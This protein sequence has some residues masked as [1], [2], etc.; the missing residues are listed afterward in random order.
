MTWSSLWIKRTDALTRF[1]LS[2]DA[3]GTDLPWILYID[4]PQPD[5]LLIGRVR[6]RLN[7]LTNANLRYTFGQ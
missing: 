5:D 2:G 3:R 7:Q 6:K 4:E 1:D